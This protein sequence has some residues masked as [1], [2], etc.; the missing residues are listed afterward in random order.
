MDQFPEQ[1]LAKEIYEETSGAMIPCAYRGSVEINDK[2]EV[3]K[4]IQV[5]R[6]EA[7]DSV[8]KLCRNN[9]IEFFN[10]GQHK[11]LIKNHLKDMVRDTVPEKPAVWRKLTGQDH[12]FHA[13]GYLTTGVKYFN[14]DFTGY[15]EQ[16]VRSIIHVV[17]QDLVLPKGDIYGRERSLSKRTW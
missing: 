9:N 4:N 12:F 1:L 2:T 11:E 16:E 8:A 3:T 13:I 10:Y 6:T 7:I 15:K 14:N 5:D 17:G